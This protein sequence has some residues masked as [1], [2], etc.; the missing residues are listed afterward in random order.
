MIIKVLPDCQRPVEVIGLGHGADERVP[1]G[2]MQFGT[3]AIYEALKR[4][5]AV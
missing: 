2:A 5:K 4:Y 3:D 1:V